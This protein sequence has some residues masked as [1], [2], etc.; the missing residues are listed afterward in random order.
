[1]TLSLLANRFTT[2]ER[3]FSSIRVKQGSIA[4]SLGKLKRFRVRSRLRVPFAWPLVAADWRA[5]SDSGSFGKLSLMSRR[6]C[7]GLCPETLLLSVRY[8]VTINSIINRERIS[9]H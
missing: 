5:G 2:P 4:S 3:G 8:Q 7:R 1:L 9:R 6:P